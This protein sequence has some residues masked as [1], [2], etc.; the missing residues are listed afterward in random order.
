MYRV[1]IM[2][3]IN[4]SLELRDTLK[5]RVIDATFAKAR[6]L[7]MLGLIYAPHILTTN[8]WCAVDYKRK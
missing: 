3:L 6:Y 5:L 2:I 1:Q 7:S 4:T 8:Q